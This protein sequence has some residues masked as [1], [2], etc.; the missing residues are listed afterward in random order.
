MLGYVWRDLVRNPRRTMASLVGITLGVGLFSGVLFFDDGSGATLTSRAIAPVAIDVQAVLNAPLGRTLRF[1]E[2]VDGTS[3]LG[4][5]DEAIVTLT[6]TNEGGVAANEVVVGGEPPAPLVYVAGSTT[7]EAGRAGARPVADVGGQSPLAQGQARTGL[8]VGRVVPGEVVTLR[9]RARAATAVSDVRALPLEGR[10][11][12]RE[13]VVPLRS[14]TPPPPTAA[15]LEAAMAGVPGVAAADA[16]S[17]VD[18]PARSLRAGRTTLDQ[19]VRIFAFDRRYQEHHPS[20]R[21]A[22]GSFQPDGVMLSA[23]A[24]RSLGAERGGEVGISLPAGAAPLTLP[25]GGILDLAQARPLFA[26]RKT[27]KL[28]DFLYVPNVVVVD[29]ATFERSVVPAFRAVAAAGG[30]VVRSLP[31]SEVDVL[32][33]RSRLEASPGPAL[34]QTLAV[35]RALERLAPGQTTLIDNISNTLSVARSDAAVGQRMFVFLGLP[36]IVLAML[37]TA[38]AGSILAATQRREQAV[39]RLR[40]ADRSRLLRMLAVKALVLA[41]VGSTVGTGAGLLSAVGALGADEIG[42]ASAGDLAASAVLAVGA[43]TL[44]T[45]LALC[46]PGFWSLRHDV[47]RERREVVLSPVPRWWRWRL[48]VVLLAGAAA[49]EA[50]ALRTGAL[51]PPRTNVSEGEAAVLPGRLLLAPL[52]AWLGGTLAT[53]RLVRAVTGRL[54]V[55]ASRFGGLVR[56]T[57][58]RSVRRRSWAL[59]SGAVGVGLVIAFAMAIAVFSATY[60]ATKAADARFTVGADLRVSPSVLAARSRATSTDASLLV[61]GV[62]SVTPVVFKLENAVLVAAFNQDRKDLAAIDAASFERTAALSDAFFEDMTTEEALEELRAD[63]GGLLVQADTAE[64]LSVEEGDEVQVLLARG[65]DQQALETFRVVGVFER[66]PGFPGGT[67]LVVNLST[68]QAATGVTAADFFLLRAGDGSRDGLSA[69]AAALRNGP[70]RLDPLD[71]ETTATALNKDQSSLTALDL[72]GLVQLDSLYATLMSAAAAGIFVFALLLQR[73]REYATL[74]AL[75][76]HARQLLA[77]VGGE[78]AVVV[79]AGLAAGI[80]VGV[81]TARLLVHIL[82]PLFLLDPVP[83]LP[84]GRMAFVGSL[85]VAAAVASALLATL[86]LRRLHPTEVLR[87]T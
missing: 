79:L 68:Y 12:S 80:V 15:Q 84:L 51:D 14:N 87:D 11:S 76:V 59:A 29:P 38:Y 55:P 44:A 31:V 8:N 16:L 65:T 6:V 81:V 85:P 20:I 21:I 22:T 24:A 23:E 56:G 1:E 7:I 71:I 4:P 66:F 35:A 82:R 50:V 32:V 67:D 60:D 72:N 74:R 83:V 54:P 61:D 73:R 49:A 64:D 43:G 57:L 78:V 58:F 27:S 53:V 26:S 18:L 36:G 63:P 70:G 69:A 30:N 45:V 41:L 34:A 25:V 86:A 17:Y 2:R 39:L 46:L 42:A 28:E 19:P 77:L 3:P 75:G 37:L 40:G 62:A 5:A 52:V 9:Y 47:Q 48:D 13:D 33:D 10:V